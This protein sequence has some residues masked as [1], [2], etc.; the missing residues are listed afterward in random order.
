MQVPSSALLVL[1]AGST[2]PGDAQ[3]RIIDTLTGA[4]V[5][6]ALVVVVRTAPAPQKLSLLEPG[7]EAGACQQPGGNKA[8]WDRAHG[9]ARGL[10]VPAASRISASG[11]T[12]PERDLNPHALSSKGF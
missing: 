7:C 2:E 9:A 12:C 4:A 11:R 1:V 5:G 6:M 8:I 3:R 10:R